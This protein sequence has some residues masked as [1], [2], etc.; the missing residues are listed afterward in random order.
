MGLGAKPR[1]GLS[2]PAPNS[3]HTFQQLLQGSLQ[4]RILSN[5]RGTL[6]GSAIAHHLDPRNF[7]TTAIISKLRFTPLIS[8]LLYR[9]ILKKEKKKIINPLLEK[10]R[11]ILLEREDTSKTTRHAIYKPNVYKPTSG[12][13]SSSRS[14]KKFSRRSSSSIEFFR[15]ISL[16]LF[17]IERGFFRRNKKKKKK[18]S[19][20]APPGTREPETK[21]LLFRGGCLQPARG[22]RLAALTH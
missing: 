8:R 19:A 6:G 18:M 20:H 17:L 7:Q 1:K 13:R 12:F 22:M 15:R 10:K 9:T 16:F 14:A 2:L 4:G 11:K 3:E 21:A 5:L